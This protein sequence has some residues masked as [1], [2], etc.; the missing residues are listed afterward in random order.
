VVSAALERLKKGSLTLAEMEDIYLRTQTPHRV[1]WPKWWPKDL[2]CK[3][4]KNEQLK[5]PRRKV[6]GTLTKS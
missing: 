6:S 3:H 4:S 5:R 2:R 1:D